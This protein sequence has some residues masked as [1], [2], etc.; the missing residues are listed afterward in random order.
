MLIVTFVTIIMMADLSLQLDIACVK[1]VI[2]AEKNLPQ[3]PLEPLVWSHL[4]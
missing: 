4:P 1:H 3:K 2:L